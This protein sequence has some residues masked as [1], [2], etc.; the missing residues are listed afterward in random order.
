MKLNVKNQVE[1]IAYVLI[2]NGATSEDITIAEVVQSQTLIEHLLH[3]ACKQLGMENTKDYYIMQNGKM[4]DPQSTI[5]ID[6]TPYELHKMEVVKQESTLKKR[7]RETAQIVRSSTVDRLFDS[8]VNRMSAILISSTI[9]DPKT[10][11]LLF[12]LDTSFVCP[13]ADT[14]YIVP[15]WNILLAE[16]CSAD[17]I[18]ILA[19]VKERLIGEGLQV[20]EKYV[21]EISLRK[22]I[23]LF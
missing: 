16:Q 5:I 7:L 8:V 15:F 6:G 21:E 11:K 4:L 14:I 23:I 1:E 13:A 20:E 12:P 3:I 22:W 10:V 18:C 19:L 9:F 2:V 17:L